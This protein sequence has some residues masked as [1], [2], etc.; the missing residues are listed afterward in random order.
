MKCTSND[1]AVA[2][3]HLL[4]RQQRYR[5]LLTEEA[6]QKRHEKTFKVCADKP[7]LFI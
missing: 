7:S 6:T 1:S 5:V 2:S 4:Y 3:E